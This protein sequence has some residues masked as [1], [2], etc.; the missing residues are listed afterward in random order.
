MHWYNIDNINEI[1][2][3]AL[4]LYTERVV[5]NIATAIGMVKDVQKLR[6]HIKTHKCLEVVK[7][8]MEAGISKFKCAT[9]AEAEMLG[10]GKAKDVL[11]AY[12]P[13]GPK[14]DRFISLIKQYPSTK[15][16][17]LTDHTDAATEMGSAFDRN[18]LTVPIYID[19]NI[20]QNRTGIDTADAVAL[21]GQCAQLKGIKPVGLHAY[22][23]HIRDID[24]D[25]R[26]QK[27]D[28]CFAS[29]IEVKEKLIHHGFE[30]PLVVAGGSPTFSIHCKR[31]EIECSPGTFIYWDKGYSDL[32]PEQKFIPAALVISRVVSLPT[33]NRICSDLGHKSIAAENEL[34]KRVFF[35]NA[36]ELKPVGQSEEHLVLETFAGHNYKIG[37]VLYGM[38]IHICPTVALYERAIIIN[39]HNPEGEWKMVARDRKIVI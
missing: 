29:V 18:G 36:A 22:D 9:I 35:L 27:C 28:A 7:L 6:P 39:N 5:Q 11:L 33:E 23:G 30:T 12:Q 34:G 25:T 20:G 21:Y 13:V 16:S 1:D 24:F 17:C 15:F 32:C 26:K 2:S 4:V 31:E 37:D 19:L 14:L 38:P 10:I 3:P 8:M